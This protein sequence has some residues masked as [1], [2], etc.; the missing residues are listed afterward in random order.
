MG[1]AL[2]IWTSWGHMFSPCEPGFSDDLNA[3]WQTE[4]RKGR[5]VLAEEEQ[6]KAEGIELSV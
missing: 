3:S 4:S 5:W 1:K 6:G 2:S